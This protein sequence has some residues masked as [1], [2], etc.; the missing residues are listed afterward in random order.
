MPDQVDDSLAHVPRLPD[1]PASKASMVAE[2]NG[3]NPVASRKQPMV[4]AVPI[5][6]QVPA[7]AQKR[8]CQSRNVS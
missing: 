5:M 2:P 6:E 4:L 8:S 3:A 7:E 1:F